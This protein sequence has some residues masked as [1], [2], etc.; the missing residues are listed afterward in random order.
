MRLIFEQNDDIV[1]QQFLDLVNPILDSIRRDRGLTDFRVV[2][3]SDPEE[4]D[5]NEMSGKIYIK[6]TR[7]L[8]Y[9]FVEFLVTPTGASFEDI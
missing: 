3:S 5:R 9:I 4:I 1:R 7:A 6:P 2:L 8:E